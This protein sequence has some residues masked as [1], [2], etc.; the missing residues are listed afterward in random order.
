MSEEISHWVVWY[1]V[2]GESELRTSK[3]L[4]EH[5]RDPLQEFPVMLA[6]KHGGTPEQADRIEVLR[7]QK[8]TVQ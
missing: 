6:I 2:T 7:I 4:L 8:G 3:C 5:G 1:R